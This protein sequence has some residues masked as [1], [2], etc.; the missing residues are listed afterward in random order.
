MKNLRTSLSH[1]I[2]QTW[3]KGHPALVVVV[4]SLFFVLTVI[5]T[6]WA[7]MQWSVLGT[8]FAISAP[9]CF[10]FGTLAAVKGRL[11]GSVLAVLTFA[12]CI[13]SSMSLVEYFYIKQ[14]DIVQDIPVSE[15]RNYPNGRIF[16]FSDAVLMCDYTGAHS[17]ISSNRER[18]GE[19]TTHAYIVCPLVPKGWTP[20]DP[21]PAWGKREYSRYTENPS[22]TFAAIA[23]HERGEYASAVKNLLK[24]YDIQ[25]FDD[26]PTLHWVRSLDSYQDYLARVR[27]SGGIMLML[28]FGGWVIFAGIYSA[29]SY[30]SQYSHSAGKTTSKLPLRTCP[31]CGVCVREDRLQNHIKKCPKRSKA[32]TQSPTEAS[33]TA[34]QPPKTT[35]E[36]HPRYKA[37][38]KVQ[39]LPQGIIIT[40]PDP[41]SFY[42]RPFGRRITIDRWKELAKISSCASQYT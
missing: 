4:G 20:A 18:P 6:I 11:E 19:T 9:L 25:T 24:T 13:V 10:A 22:G 35:E 34:A 2:Y 37:R 26:A 31:H 38:A 17:T 27:T 32:A 41:R 1:S 7:C 39:D 29:K 21:V 8:L 23:P 42:G 15:T 12:F 3:L 33:Q 28:F 40:L 36:E 16:D 5:P 30:K 14:G